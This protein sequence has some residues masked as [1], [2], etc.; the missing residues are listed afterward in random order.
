MKALTKKKRFLLITSL[1]A[2]LIFDLGVRGDCDRNAISCAFFPENTLSISEN[3][4]TSGVS[5]PA[6]LAAISK[7][8]QIYRS[9]FESIGQ[10]FTIEQTWDDDRVN[11]YATRDDSGNPVVIASGGLARHPLMT[12]DGML[13]VLCHEVGHFMGGAPKIHRGNTDLLSWSS[14]EGEADYFA[15]AKCLKDL[16]SDDQEN[17]AVILALPAE[18][19]RVL[20]EKCS[21]YQC[22]RI[23]EAAQSVTNVFA[24]VTPFSATPD[25]ETTDSTSTEATLYI[26]PTPQCRLDTFVHGALCSV[27][28]TVVID[29]VNPAKGACTDE[30]GGRPSCWFAQ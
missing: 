26:H 7:V 21:S 14:A 15:A 3:S 20:G 25:L 24:A 4:P 8:L 9:R 18:R 28:S 13:A 19:Q 10:N 27:P 22:M 30:Q 1:G 23:L 12:S 6:Y 17:E 11:S 2:L 29:N 5:K 16:F